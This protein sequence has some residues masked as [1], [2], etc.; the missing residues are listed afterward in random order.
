MNTSSFTST[1]LAFLFP[2][3]HSSLVDQLGGEA[4][5]ECRS[6]IWRRICPRTHCMGIPE[7]RGYA[8]AQAA[9]SLPAEVDR[10][11]DR[12]RLGYSLKNRVLAAGLEQ[13]VVMLVRDSFSEPYFADSEQ[14]AA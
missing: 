2:W 5:R 8:R 14:I 9:E 13:I 12:H 3:H 1:L 7:I 4:A 10:V 6:D 11:L